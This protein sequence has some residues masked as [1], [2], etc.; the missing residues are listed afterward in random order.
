MLEL[1]GGFRLDVRKSF[2]LIELQLTYS[3]MLLARAQPTAYCLD[4]SRRYA[5]LAQ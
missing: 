3:V 4:S 5:V 2:F 1:Q